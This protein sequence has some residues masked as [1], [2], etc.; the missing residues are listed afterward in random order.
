VIDLDLDGAPEVLTNS[1]TGPSGYLR[2]LGGRD[3][4]HVFTVQDPASKL[5]WGSQIAAGNLDGDPNPEIVA[6]ASDATHLLAFEHDGTLKWRSALLETIGYGGAALADLDG[7]GTPEIVV[8]RQ[9]LNADGT[10]RWTGTGGRSDSYV[11]LSLVSDLDRDGHPEIVAGATAYRANGS[12]YWRLTNIGDG[13]DA[14]GNFD[15]D[16]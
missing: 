8:G 4:H 5:H 2:A 12:I 9:A 1:W 3:G 6:V 10:L 7:D 15:S 13:Y 14:I 11:Q 16:P